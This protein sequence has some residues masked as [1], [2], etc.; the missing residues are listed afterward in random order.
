MEF[1]NNWFSVIIPVLNEEELIEQLLQSIYEQEYRPIE[2]IVVD[3]GSEDRTP[4]IVR[5]AK[6]ALENQRFI[7]RLF[8]QGDR[9]GLSRAR[10]IGLSNS[11]GSY[12]IFVDGD[13]VFLDNSHLSKLAEMLHDHPM[14]LYKQKMLVNSWFELNFFWDIHGQTIKS[15]AFRRETLN[16]V[17]FDPSLGSGD[18]IYFY[19]QL[20]GQCILSDKTP[21]VDVELGMHTYHSFR[22]YTTSKLWHGRTMWPYLKK[23][24]RAICE[25]LLSPTAPF[26]LL[27][28]A[29]I[30]GLFHLGM[31]I[32][33]LV[34]WSFPLVYLFIGSPQRSLSRL[35][36]ILLN[37]TYGSF[38]KTLGIIIG[39]VEYLKGTLTPGRGR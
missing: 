37:L 3:G 8:F 2:V 16:K 20:R 6:R 30:I 12:V 38:V 26:G 17:M 4:H 25:K 34:L 15:P 39:L 19:S 24:P 27:L 18:D 23:N 14:V 1:N 7:I 31:S 35:A 22:E 33:F 21:T 10:N 28:A 13:N 11:R 36:Y 29:A 5:K 9:K 32:V